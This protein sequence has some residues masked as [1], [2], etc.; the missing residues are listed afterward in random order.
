VTARRDGKF[1][2]VYLMLCL[3]GLGLGLGYRCCCALLVLLDCCHHVFFFCSLLYPLGLTG[4]SRRRSWCDL[5]I[6]IQG[7][8]WWDWDGLFVCFNAHHGISGILIWVVRYCM[9]IGVGTLNT[10]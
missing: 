6:L 5:V 2:V 7:D 9:F 10:Y 8:W 1:F 4:G 3:W